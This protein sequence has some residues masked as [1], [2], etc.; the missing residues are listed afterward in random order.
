MEGKLRFIGVAIWGYVVS[1]MYWIV[2]KYI[3]ICLLTQNW[4]KVLW[5]LLLIWIGFQF[6]VYL[7]FVM[8]MFLVDSSIMK[9]NANRIITSIFFIFHGLYAIALP[10]LCYPFGEEI[11]VAIFINIFTLIILYQFFRTLKKW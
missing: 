9:I 2:V 10:W 5:K 8:P 11:M 6:I 1:Y 7:I 3:T 4:F